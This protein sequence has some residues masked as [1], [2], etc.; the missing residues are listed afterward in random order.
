MKV[1]AANL[2]PP[3][4]SALVAAL[5]FATAK[6]QPVDLSVQQSDLIQTEAGPV[7]GFVADGVRSFLGLPYATPPIGPLRWRP[8]VSP[9]PW[10]DVLVADKFGNSCVQTQTFGR[11]AQKSMSEDCLYLN[12]FT[13]AS[14]A[15]HLRP[16]MVWLHGG[17][18]INGR[19]DDYDSS[20]LV[21]QGDVV[22]VTLN[23]RLNVFGFLA[24]PA[25]DAEGHPF[26][27]YGV[28]D[29]QL[30][31][32]WVQ[33]NIKAFGGDPENVTLFGQS[34]GGL[35]VLFNLIS[36]PARNLFQK[37]I[38]ESGVSVS[39]QTPLSDAE[40]IGR[41][42]S[43]VAGC[44]D[45]T[46]SCLR[47]LSVEQ[48]VDRAG[49]YSGLATRA[50]DGT[51][52]PEQVQ[53]AL[54]SG[55]FNKVPVLMGN[56]Q[57][58]FT[59]FI[60]LNEI[61][62]QRPLAADD[63]ATTLTRLFGDEK[64]NRVVAEYPQE[65]YTSPSEALAAAETSSYFV[66]PSY[67]A[68]RSLAKYVPVYAYEFID[69]NAPSPYDPVSFPYRAGHTLELQYLFKGFH[70]ARGTQQSLDEAQQHLSDIMVSYWTKFAASSNPNAPPLP[71]WP[72]YTSVAQYEQLLAAPQ[73]FSGP[74]LSVDHRCDFWDRLGQ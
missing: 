12:V 57:D 50:V 29:Q 14:R 65:S 20:K 51:I 24:Q 56:N 48:I 7:K 18:L 38:L 60:S 11:F 34:A 43:T 36:P 31:L 17:G 6:G 69:R 2:L 15:Q 4:A 58:E 55:H 67:R 33:Q 49:S 3:I 27:N 52:I 54:A 25:L 66:C 61:A 62:G 46:A 39:P 23:Y 53:Q 72:V 16:V 30:A 47:A 26:S 73:P 22:V 74:L 8:P 5:L 64:A 63:Y 44:P 1:R 19:A 35:S 41:K 10:T 21:A 71:A 37:A 59:W 32:Q 70:G 13:P 42:F 28:M 9:A 40:G 68:M 45:Q